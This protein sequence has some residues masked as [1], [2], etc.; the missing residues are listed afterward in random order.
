MVNDPWAMYKD[1]RDF[2]RQFFQS[3][4]YKDSPKSQ[5]GK[6]LQKTI[7]YKLESE[8]GYEG[9]CVVHNK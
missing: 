4:Y 2:L 6:I 5:F 9:Y 8:R 3:A 7:S 1:V